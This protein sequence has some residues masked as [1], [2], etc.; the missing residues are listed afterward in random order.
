MRGNKNISRK[1]NPDEVYGSEV[2]TKFIN[3]IMMDGKKTVAQEIVYNALEMLGKNT[4]TA[5]VEALEKALDNVK[6][7]L[8]IRSKRVGGANLQVPTPVPP[9]RQLALAFRWLIGS[10]RD[11]RK[12][13]AFWIV[14][15]KELEM[16]FNNE[17]NAVR[18]RDDV[19]RMA[20]ANRAFAQFAMN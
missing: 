13:D 6:P 19:Q 3:Y 14:L 11:A 10:A 2:V 4:K 18:K 17:G 20:E 16:A 12:K 8:E 9:Y 7:K 5:P 1:V 15:A